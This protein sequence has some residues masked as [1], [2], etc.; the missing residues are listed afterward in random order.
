MEKSEGAPE[1]FKGRTFIFFDKE[2]KVLGL[3][4]IVLTPPTSVGY[5]G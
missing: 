3:D 2:H 1:Q 4:K 5:L